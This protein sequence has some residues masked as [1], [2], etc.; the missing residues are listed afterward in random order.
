L[1]RADPDGFLIAGRYTLLDQEAALRKLLPACEA[2]NLGIVVGGP[3][4]SG[5]LAGGT[6]FEYQLAP[7]AMIDRVARIREVCV[8]FGVDIRAAALQFSLAHPAVAGIIPGASRPSRIVENHALMT[9][10]IPVAFWDQL[11][12]G[13]LIAAHAPTPDEV[14]PAL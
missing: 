7:Q 4:N 3:Y 12:S 2:R 6:H 13:N 8:Q 5:L 9:A 11:K 10:P 1:E 14:S